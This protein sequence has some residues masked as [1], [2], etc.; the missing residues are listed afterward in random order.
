MKTHHWITLVVI[1]VVVYVVWKRMAGK[2]TAG[3]SGG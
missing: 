2:V 1:A 3:A